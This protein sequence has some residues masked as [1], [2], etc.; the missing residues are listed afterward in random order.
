[1]KLEMNMNDQQKRYLMI[2][3]ITIGAAALLAYP[4]MQLVKMIRNRKNS[5]V[6]E[7][8]SHMKSFAPSY[9]GSHKP[10]HR[11]AEANSDSHLHN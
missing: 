4:V 3:G 2:A 1:M 8:T 10:H 5:V 6:Q 7:E 9:R 11:K